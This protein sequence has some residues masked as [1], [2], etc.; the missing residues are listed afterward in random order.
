ML[1]NYQKKQSKFRR[2]LQIQI[3]V[4]TNFMPRLKHR[5]YFEIKERINKFLKKFKMSTNIMLFRLLQ[6]KFKLKKN[7]M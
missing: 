7:Y 2:V 1:N 3:W 5:K 4:E 6:K